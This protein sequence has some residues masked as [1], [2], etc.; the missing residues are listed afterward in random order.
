MPL[1]IAAT[2]VRSGPRRVFPRD[3]INA[4]AVLAS[5]ALPHVFRAVREDVHSYM[6]I[7]GLTRSTPAAGP[8]WVEGAQPGMSWSS[9]SRRS[10]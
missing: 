7:R 6:K 8:V 5:A 9:R 4:D 3:K 10:A 1:F 2:N